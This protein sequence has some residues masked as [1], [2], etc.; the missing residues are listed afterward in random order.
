MSVLIINE[1]YRLFTG[2]IRSHRYYS[3]DKKH[4]IYF[5][6]VL[7]TTKRNTFTNLIYFRGN[8]ISDD[9]RG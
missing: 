6:I 7:S 5:T 1:I 8:Y 4:K 3:F 2:A 9:N